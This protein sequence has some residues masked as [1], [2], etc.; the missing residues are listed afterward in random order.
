MAKR[1]G[2]TQKTHNQQSGP[3]KK[4][5]SINLPAISEGREVVPTNG[6]GDRSDGKQG[7]IRPASFA[8][9]VITLVVLAIYTTYS[10]EQ[11]HQS[12][13]ANSIAEKALTEVNKPY[14]VMT[15]FSPSRI[16]ENGEAHW[17][18]GVTW[19]NVGNTPTSSVR[20]YICNPIIRD[21][22]SVPNF[23][24]RFS[25]PPSPSIVIGPK[26]SQSFAGPIVDD[27]VLEGLETEKKVLYMFGYLRYKN[28]FEAAQ[29][30]ASDR[31]TKFC[32]R[33]I[34]PNNFPVANIRSGVGLPLGGFGCPAQD[35][36]CA[37]S[38]CSSPP[39][40]T[41]DQP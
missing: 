32:Q 6:N 9:N 1:Q 2:Y 30:L 25:D 40:G 16:T 14:M 21:N 33:V 3:N 37:D 41:A 19:M 31:F 36:N 28:S 34:V 23:E 18:I 13:R 5:A 12:G 15:G 11:V 17:R 27:A 35:W 24:C 26:V 22:V 4:P 39:P 10:C 20:V 7:W 8:V 38:G 29:P